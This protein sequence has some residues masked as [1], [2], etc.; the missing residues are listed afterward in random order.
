MED[1]GGN[2]LLWNGE[3][4]AILQGQGQQVLH[5]DKG[6]EESDTDL[7]MRR[8]G[9]AGKATDYGQVVDLIRYALRCF[10]PS[11]T[12]VYVPAHSW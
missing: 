4:Y 9:L 5:E 10:S 11:R 8:L 7:V 3:L 12:M 2:V 6:E 1:G